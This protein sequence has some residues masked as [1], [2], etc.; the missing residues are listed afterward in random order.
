MTDALLVT[1]VAARGP[2]HRFRGAPEHATTQPASIGNKA[3]GKAQSKINGASWV[4][5]P[6]PS[7]DVNKQIQ[8]SKNARLLWQEKYNSDVNLLKLE[9]KLVSG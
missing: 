9:A 2:L 6:G 1:D 4:N 5:R 3:R 8:L 7:S